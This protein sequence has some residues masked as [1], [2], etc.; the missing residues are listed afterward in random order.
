MTLKKSG[1][2]RQESK[3][4]ED[5]KERGPSLTRFLFEFYYVTMLTYA[6][7]L[8]HVKS[9]LPVD[10]KIKNSTKCKENDFYN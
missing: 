4:D 9:H 1:K 7:K 8:P 10:I 5:I 3:A 2:I 6:S